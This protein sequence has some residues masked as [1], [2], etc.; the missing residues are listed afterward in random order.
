[1][2]RGREEAGFS[3]IRF[4]FLHPGRIHIQAPK[5]GFVQKVVFFSRAGFLLH[6]VPLLVDL[7]S[8][9]RR[10]LLLPSKR[11]RNAPILKNPFAWVCIGF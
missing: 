3:E 7:R 1:M 8:F 4:L 10:F 5:K 6:F 11:H 9:Y 2:V